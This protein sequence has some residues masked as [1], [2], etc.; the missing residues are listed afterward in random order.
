MMRRLCSV[1]RFSISIKKQFG[2]TICLQWP[3][4]GSSLP[5]RDKVRSEVRC[6]DKQVY[7][8]NQIIF[9]ILPERK[10]EHGL[11]HVALHQVDASVVLAH[12][13]P[14]EGNIL[15]KYIAGDKIITYLCKE[16]DNANRI[17]TLRVYIQILF[18]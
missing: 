5:S 17:H 9:Q 6:K 7:L 3:F 13:L 1:V 8:I 12:D 18:E 14:G 11:V 15:T 2:S 4:P 16:K 10:L